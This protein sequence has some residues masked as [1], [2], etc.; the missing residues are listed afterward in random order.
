[1]VE[2]PF[3]QLTINE[4]CVT[5]PPGIVTDESV[6]NGAKVT[7]TVAPADSEPL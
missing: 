5:L 4:F 6:G 1:M 3:D 2:T 7:S